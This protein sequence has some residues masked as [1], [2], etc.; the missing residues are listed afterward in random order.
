LQITRIRSGLTPISASA[1]D[2]DEE[3]VRNRLLRCA[4]G[5]SVFSANRPA[6]ETG[7]RKRIGHR[8]ACT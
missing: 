8:S 6:V 4:H 3:T 1:A 2:V 7:G 5:I